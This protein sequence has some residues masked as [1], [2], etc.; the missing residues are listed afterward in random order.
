M[1]QARLVLTLCDEW[2]SKKQSGADPGDCRTAGETFLRLLG[3]K[4]WETISSEVGDAS[5]VVHGRRAH[6]TVAF[7]VIHKMKLELPSSLVERGMDYCDCTLM[8]AGEAQEDGY[9]FVVV[10]DFN[11]FYLYEVQSDELLVYA[12]SPREFT[13]DMMEG[14]TKEVVDEIAFEDMHRNPKSL[15]ARQLR[16]WCQD[17]F[18]KLAHREYN[19]ERAADAILDRMVMLRFLYEHPICEMEDWSFREQFDDV[20]SLAFEGPAEDVGEALLNVMGELNRRWGM[21]FFARDEQV[22][23]I[24]LDAQV[25]VPLIR[26]LALHGQ[27]KFE[28]STILESF[29]YGDASEKARVRLVPEHS[30]ERESLIRRLCDEVLEAGKLEV[31]VLDEG[32]RIIVHWVDRLLERYRDMGTDFSAHAGAA[33]GLGDGNDLLQW[34]QVENGNGPKDDGVLQFAVKNGFRIWYDSERQYRT[35]RVIMYMYLIEWYQQHSLP[36]AQF[37]DVGAMLDKR[38]AMLESDKKWIYNPPSQTLD[39]WDAI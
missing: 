30:E 25:A 32:Y 20:A 31:D 34:S 11:R 17:W 23:R 29:N 26:E 12:D 19:A 8:L 2:W 9:D 18:N 22:E 15:K 35:A 16:R 13:T 24:L 14:V 27:A 6:S 33:L 3:W 21:S 4:T 37:P 38:P 36:C 10:T 5:F 1:D 7:H 28:S 39:E